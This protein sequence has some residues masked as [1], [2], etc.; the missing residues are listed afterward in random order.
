MYIWY[1][2]YPLFL[3][4]CVYVIV[5]VYTITNTAENSS[6]I[7]I[8]R[9]ICYKIFHLPSVMHF[10]LNHCRLGRLITD[11]SMF[12][13]GLHLSGLAIEAQVAEEEKEEY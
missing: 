3:N 10:S 11:L 4:Y 8:P 13:S 6:I 5:L 2:F 7:L 9:S 12:I 1:L